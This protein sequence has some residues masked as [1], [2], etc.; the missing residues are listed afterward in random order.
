MTT[1]T[2]NSK[3]FFD[4]SKEESSTILATLNANNIFTIEDFLNSR[5]KLLLTLFSKETYTSMIVNCRAYD[6]DSKS[7][8]IPKT[9]KIIEI[10][11]AWADNVK[12]NLMVERIQNNEEDLEGLKAIKRQLNVM[13][14]LTESHIK[15]LL[16]KKSKNEQ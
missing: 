11:P 5:A 15:V 10:L 2:I 7:W 4:F 14:E 12:L 3:L 6:K 16:E 8:F 1:I 9:E 13:L